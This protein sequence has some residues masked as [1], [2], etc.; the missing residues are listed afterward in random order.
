MFIHTP[1]REQIA[2]A[3]QLPV[4]D[5]RVREAFLA[6]PRHAFV[7]AFLERIPGE[8]RGQSLWRPHY[9]N[10]FP[11]KAWFERVYRDEA[12]VT[13]VD[14]CGLPVSS[15]SQPSIMARM[16]EWLD[17]RK[18]Q[19]LL[20]IGAGT[21]FNAALLAYLTGDP[22]LVTTIDIDRALAE[23]A[24]T[25]IIAIAGE[26]VRV[27]VGDGLNGVGEFAPYDRIIA[28]GATYPVPWSWLD[29]LALGGKLLMNLRTEFLSCGM[30][31]ATKQEDG[32]VTGHILH[33]GGSFMYLHNGEYVRHRLDIPIGSRRAVVGTYRDRHPLL[34]PSQ[35]DYGFFVQCNIPTLCAYRVWHK[36]A[37]HLYFKEAKS[38]RW[39]QLHQGKVRGSRLLWWRLCLLDRAWKRYG[40]P[41]CYQFWAD[42]KR[43]GV[44]CQ[45]HRWCLA[46]R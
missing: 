12:L 8:G 23:E 7:S 26:G 28:T 25:A 32:Y 37:L 45:R 41:S 11:E 24:R 29:Q 2:L 22:T 13:R 40:A 39:I 1:C 42:G 15:T 18:G 46:A 19:R 43:Q 9:R 30:L 38:G 16:L 4:A 27:V 35:R 14:G 6:V 33:S 5:P 3:E 20:E 21:G 34:E 10:E 44:L 17:V 31:L 36:D